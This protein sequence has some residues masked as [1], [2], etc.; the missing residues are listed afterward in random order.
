MM[1]RV[2]TD[3][4]PAA[5][6]PYSQAVVHGDLVFVSGQIPVDPT[7]GS[8]PED[9]AEQTAQALRN[10]RNVLEAAGSGMDRVLRVTVF[11]RDISRFPDVN[12]VYAGF[13]TEPYPSRSCVEVSGLPKGVSVEI[14][15]IAFRG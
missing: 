2:S 5:V 9:I 8:V 13:F 10:L 11:V 12:A 3:S 1:E 6:G 4:A 14:D 15:A 7:D